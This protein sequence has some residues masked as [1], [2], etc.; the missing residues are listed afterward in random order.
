MTGAADS[1]RKP[2]SEAFGRALRAARQSAGLSQQSLALECAMSRGFLSDLERGNKEPTLSTLLRLASG[3][4]MSA[5][6]LVAMAEREL[7]ATA[8]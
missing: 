3:L 5:G 4:E 7:A 8:E 1:D 2:S 6:E